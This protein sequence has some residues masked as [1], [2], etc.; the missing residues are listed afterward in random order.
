[1]RILIIEDNE[2]NA[3]CLRRLL[4]SVIHNTSV[5]TVNNSSSALTLFYSQSFDLVILDG[6][7]GAARAK[8]AYCNGPELVSILLYKYPHIN[9][10]AWT[11]SSIMRQEFD[12]IF[13]QYGRKLD[14]IGL[15]NK[16]VAV[17]TIRKT[18][19]HYFPEKTP[20][21]STSYIPLNSAYRY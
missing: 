15:W 9:L 7:L 14:D 12:V 16:T 11:D 10:I 19:T 3:F 1:M 8:D 2:F 18:I 20:N 5:T 13:R 17:E 6:D 21:L 4:E